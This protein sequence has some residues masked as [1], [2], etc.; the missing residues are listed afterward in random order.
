MKTMVASTLRG[1]QSRFENRLGTVFLISGGAALSRPEFSS[2]SA[3][4]IPAS[5]PLGGR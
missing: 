5:L 3:F 1:R 4:R 2:F